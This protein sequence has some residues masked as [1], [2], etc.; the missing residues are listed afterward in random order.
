MFTW[1][2]EPIKVIYFLWTKICVYSDPARSMHNAKISLTITLKQ[3]LG[4]EQARQ[5]KKGIHK[6]LERA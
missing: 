1:D 3:L 4:L 2:E 6:T 5:Y